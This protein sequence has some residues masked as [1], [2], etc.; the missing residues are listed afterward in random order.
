MVRSLACQTGRWIDE[1]VPGR[2]RWQ[3]RPVRVVDGTTVTLPDTPDN[4]TAYPQ[5]GGQATGLGFPI[6]RLVGVTCLESSAL[7]DAAL[8]H[9][10]GKGGDE[11]TLLRSLVDAFSA[12]DVVL[13]DASCATWFLIADLQARG[14]DAL[15]EQNGARR[16]STDFRRGR[17]LGSKDHLITWPR[18]K[19]RPQWM[20][21]EQYAATPESITVRELQAGKRILVTMMRC[22]KAAS[23]RALKALYKSRWNIELDIR[24][25]K[26]TLGMETLSCRTP[27]MAEKEL[28]IH[29]LAYNLIRMLML[30]SARSV[31]ALPRVLSFR[32]ALQLWLAW[33]RSTAMLDEDDLAQLL[34]L[35][36]Q[37]RVGNRSGRVEPRAVKRRPKAFP[38]LTRT[39][40]EAR[41]R[42]RYHGH[43]AKVK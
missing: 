38:L 26:T 30:Q 43:P 7:L 4:Q 37:Q 5:Q 31:D 35:I 25:I 27:E 11:Q 12:G 29:L 40:P 13:G 10:Q 18:P 21:P 14:V 24:S 16:R 23:G 22:P 1:A 6:C 39:R 32:H 9:F 36:A 34:Q 41:E 20:S 8:G 15:F 17:R 42:I 19:V 33:A 28:W 3:G 2:W